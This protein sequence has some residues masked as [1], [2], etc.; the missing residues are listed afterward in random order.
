MS[1]VSEGY[2][3]VEYPPVCVSVPLKSTKGLH[4]LS[5][6][7]YPPQSPHGHGIISNLPMRKLSFKE[8]G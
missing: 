1:G 8:V 3:Y 7:G 5:V 4:V 2:V 6:T